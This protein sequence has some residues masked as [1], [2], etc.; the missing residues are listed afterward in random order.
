VRAGFQTYRL[1]RLLTLDRKTA[2]V[3]S[4]VLGDGLHISTLISRG[5]KTWA[6]DGWRAWGGGV[7]GKPWP[8]LDFNKNICVGARVMGAFGGD[9]SL[10]GGG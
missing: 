6:G 1:Y 3:V 5:R 4:S 8:E 9:R 2:C 7:A 10:E